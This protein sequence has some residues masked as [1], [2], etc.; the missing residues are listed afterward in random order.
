[1]FRNF[2]KSAAS[3]LIASVI[4]STALAAN[5]V[6]DPGPDFVQDFCK[7]VESYQPGSQH[8]FTCLNKGHELLSQGVSGAQLVD[9]ICETLADLLYDASSLSRC[10]QDGSL[11]LGE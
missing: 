8:Y 7:T 5:P 3:L 6:L 9:G 10:Y 4:Q 1:M 2:Q 11:L